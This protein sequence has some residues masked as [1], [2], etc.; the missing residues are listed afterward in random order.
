[1][2]ARLI[3]AVLR[4]KYACLMVSSSRRANLSNA[5]SAPSFPLSGGDSIYLSYKISQHPT[6]VHKMTPADAFSLIENVDYV[7]FEDN[8]TLE[9]STACTQAEEER[10]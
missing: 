4:L 6:N 2:A 10:S 8:M 7:T 3:R 5:V 9:S 1:M